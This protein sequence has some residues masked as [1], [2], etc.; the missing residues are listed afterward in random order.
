MNENPTTP[1]K[2]FT[3]AVFALLIVHVVY[4]AYRTRACFIDDAY[5]DLQYLRNLL[6]GHGFVFHPGGPVVEGIT[7]VGWLLCLMPFAVV[8]EP[9][10]AAKLLGLALLLLTFWLTFCL[11]TKLDAASD[12]RRRPITGLAIV[13]L[14]LLLSSFDFL[15]F[16]LAGMETALL[17][18]VLLSM[19]W[20]AMRRPDSFWLP[21]AGAFAF[22]V[23]PEAIVVFPLYTLLTLETAE[24][25]QRR[26]LFGNLVLAVLVGL[27]TAV[28]F[29][30]FNDVLPNTFHSKPSDF[31]RII[32]GGFSFLSARNVNIPFPITGWLAL[33]V[34][35]L[36]YLR[37][38][39]TAPR[40][41]AML[42][43]ITVT[44]LAFGVYSLP[45]WTEMGRYFAPYLPAALIL[46]WTGTVEVIRRLLA[47]VSMRPA[48]QLAAA[49]IIVLLALIGVFNGMKKMARMD[50]F[51]G[52]VLASRNLVGP[53]RWIGE[54]LPEDATIACRRIGAL[55]YFSRRTV[56]DYTSGLPDREV[57]RLV[58]DA[59]HRFN[60]P[61]DP[62]LAE[63]WSDR[64]PDYLLEDAEI[65]D[66]IAAD[67]GGTRQ[68]F[69]VHGIPYGVTRSFQIGPGKHWM[70]TRR[71]DA[72]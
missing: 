62:A 72:R 53:S 34:L 68:R 28:R 50:D 39:R 29:G 43:A 32:A 13:P 66:L 1:S 4:F 9:A 65:I 58:S 49:A 5:I 47:T 41:T 46:F 61:T 31:S 57:A 12:Q 22:L 30:Y 40:A 44:G 2:R 42:G 35:L 24:A 48:R 64:S 71:L 55:A 56:L 54:S 45:D 60:L 17:A 14:V 16:S 63:L 52:Y 18:V 10:I 8:F 67:T 6:A 21:V 19:A 70:L 3:W 69:T 37:L 51:P 7:N 26:L 27:A 11:A 23:H 36:G 20:L 38:R 15:Y 59:G 25:D 33:P